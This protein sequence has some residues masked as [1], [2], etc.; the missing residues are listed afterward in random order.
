MQT[1]QVIGVLVASHPTGRTD[2]EIADSISVPDGVRCIVQ[3]GFVTLEGAVEWRSQRDN[4]EACVRNLPGV[5]GVMNNL[6]VR[7]GSGAVASAVA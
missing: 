6:A 5:R 4:L 1:K 7:S 2:R 3:N